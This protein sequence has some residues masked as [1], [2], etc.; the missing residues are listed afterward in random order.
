LIDEGVPLVMGKVAGDVGGCLAHRYAEAVH[1]VGAIDHADQNSR[2]SMKARRR[3]TDQ[4]G[5]CRAAFAGPRVGRGGEL[6]AIRGFVGEAA[7][8][9]VI[10]I[11]APLPDRTETDQ[12]D[13][14]DGSG[15]FP[16]AITLAAYTEHVTTE[17]RALCT[18]LGLSGPERGA[19]LRAARWHD[20][21]KAHSVFQDT[22]RRGVGDPARYEAVLLAKSEN[23]HLRHSRPYFRHELASALAF[24][25]HGNWARKADFIA[26]LIASHHGKLR[27]GRHGPQASAAPI[28]VECRVHPQD[29]FC[30]LICSFRV[31]RSYSNKCLGGGI[32]TWRGASYR[33]LERF[34][35]PPLRRRPRK[36]QM[37]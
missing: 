37:R 13:G 9:P 32:A 8:T 19:I 25:A 10:P 26:Y 27:N 21:G 16:R 17:A 30:Q 24:L 23:Q 1:N 36:H 12:V 15:G 14:D 4:G 18:A 31:Y 20:L 35:S 5:A 3:S 6:W 33:C 2:S 29:F 7:L 22:M 11:D 34:S 28:I